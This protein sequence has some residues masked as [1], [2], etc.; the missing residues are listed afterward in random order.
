MSTH[1]HCVMSTHTEPIW[2]CSISQEVKQPKR[3]PAL[4][5]ISCGTLTQQQ[6]HTVRKNHELQHQ[7][8]PMH[9]RHDVKPNSVGTER[10][11]REFNNRQHMRMVGTT[12]KG[13]KG[14][15]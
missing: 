9:L 4:E 8:Q 13:I 6:P 12:A 2:L 14:A 10:F 3:P 5:W 7:H 1:T 15:L 11:D